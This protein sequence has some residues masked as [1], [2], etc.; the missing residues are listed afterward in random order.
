MP[1]SEPSEVV[2]LVIQH[3]IRPGCLPAYEAWLKRALAAA[4]QQTGHLGVNV[5]LSLIHI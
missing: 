4:E 5:I 1:T 2:T 3:K